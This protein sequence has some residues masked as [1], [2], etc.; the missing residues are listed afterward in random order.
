MAEGMVR[1]STITDDY[2]A[3]FPE[4]QELLGERTGRVFRLG[5]TVKV[6]L[7]EANLDRL[8]VN[9]RLVDGGEMGE[10]P[11]KRGR[12][13]KAPRPARPAKSGRSAKPAGKA[14]KPATAKT[15]GGAKRA[16][17]SRRGGGKRKR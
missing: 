3:F 5:Q 15:E 14:E 12:R 7:V 4:R 16:G 17:G 8:E 6:E 11:A 1:L 2:Y 9:L 10:V 13:S